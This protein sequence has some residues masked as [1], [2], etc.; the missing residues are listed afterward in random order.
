MD[1]SKES[2]SID[3]WKVDRSKG[4]KDKRTLTFDKDTYTIPPRGRVQVYVHYHR[5]KGVRTDSENRPDDWIY[6]FESGTVSMSEAGLRYELSGSLVQSPDK[7]D[8]FCFTFT[9]SSTAESGMEFPIAIMTNDGLVSD[10]AKICISGSSNDGLDW[11]FKPEYVAQYGEV[12]VTDFPEAF[13]PV[14]AKVSDASVLSVKRVDDDTFRV[15]G[16]KVGVS[17]LVFETSKG[18]R[19][20]KC[21]MTINAPE[22]ILYDDRIVLSPDGASVPLM[23]GYVDRNGDA[24]ELKCFDSQVFSSKLALDFCE[25]GFLD[26]EMKGYDAYVHVCRLWNQGKIVDMEAY[27]Y[28]NIKAA[29][30]ENVSQVSIAA[31]V[32]DPFKG[33]T[34]IDY[35]RIDDYSLFSIPGVNKSVY[36]KFASK[37]AESRKHKFYA[38]AVR[39][40]M[41]SVQIELIPRWQDGFSYENQVFS[42]SYM[43]D[44]SFSDGMAF[45]IEQNEIT[46][47]T[48]HGAGTHDIMMHV[49]NRISGEKISFNCGSIDIYVH[50]A[51][52]A[53]AEFAWRYADHTGSESS[54]MTLNFAEA[55]NLIARGQNV[56]ETT[57]MK[58]YYMDVNTE[59]LTEVTGV[60]VF[61]RLLSASLSGENQMDAQ[62]VV[63]PSVSDGT[64]NVGLGLMYSVCTTDS[65]RQ[66]LVLEPYGTRRGVGPMLY[67]ALS[68]KSNSSECSEDDLHS[69]FLGS[70]RNGKASVA[71]SP[72]YQVID[73]KTGRRIGRY[74][75]WY[76]APSQY[77]DRVNKD[78]KGYH[79]VHFLDD[80]CPETAGWI[81]LL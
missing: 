65:L 62:Y 75:L 29:D 31:Y 72:C 1:I 57:D 18:V 23:Y 46:E 36:D 22:L 24:L 68:L 12:T 32:T 76:F 16:L 74:S 54:A 19:I 61:E 80:I 20:A 41:T 51:I 25:E 48:R 56:S 40:V 59:F 78:G 17:D 66:D 3:N 81:N 34:A 79:V 53:R 47:K 38:P 30:C 45:S 49:V 52:G 60:Q 21:S 71:Y 55:C 37:L 13:G 33:M 44:H 6:D 27:H 14:V 73:V 7:T 50:T 70:G 77:P 63:C 15:V 35:G 8:D 64:V 69:C 26:V 28:Q 58:V 9:A 10:R 42:L 4:W 11:S 2:F 43:E 5:T 39:A 67:R